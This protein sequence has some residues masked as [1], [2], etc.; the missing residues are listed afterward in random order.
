M[1]WRIGKLLFCASLE[2]YDLETDIGEKNN[3]AG[4]HPE[5]VK[6]TEDYL[7]TARTV[8]GKRCRAGAMIDGTR[9]M[10]SRADAGY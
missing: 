2:L 6:E 1:R 9:G 7:K 8:I 3:I 4:K 5:V 10:S